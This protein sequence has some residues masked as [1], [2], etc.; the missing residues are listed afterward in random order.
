MRTQVF[1]VKDN[2]AGLFQLPFYSPSK[3]AAERTFKDSLTDPQS[4]AARHPEDYDLYYVGEFDDEV[5]VLI[6]SEPEFLLTGSSF[7]K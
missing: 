4:P 3:G 2:V 5:G 1:A 6:S 7:S